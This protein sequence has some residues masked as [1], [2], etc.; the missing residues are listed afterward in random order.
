MLEK[1]HRSHLPHQAPE[2]T[3]GK[4]S[5]NSKICPGTFQSYLNSQARQAAIKA[6]D[7]PMYNNPSSSK[8]DAVFPA[9]PKS[10]P[11]KWTG[12]KRASNELST[13]N[14]HISATNNRNKRVA[15][16]SQPI[17]IERRKDPL[18]NL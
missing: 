9:P 8:P 1:N 14:S 12:G 10:P 7:Q 11:S 13:G 4:S 3:Q 16:H 18:S 15:A 2:Q 6:Q 17:G 5:K